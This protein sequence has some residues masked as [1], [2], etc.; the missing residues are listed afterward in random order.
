MTS[1]YCK[2][3]MKK[4]ELVFIPFPAIGHL[5]PTVE[6]AKLLTQRDP[7]LSVTIFIMSFSFEFLDIIMTNNCSHDSVRFVK[8]PPVDACPEAI[9]ALSISQFL[10]ANI[11]LVRNAVH[12]LTRSDSVRLAGFVLDMGFT[13]LIDLADDFGVPSYVFVTPG[14]AFLGFLLHL[15]FLHDHQGLDIDGFKDSDAELEVPSY[16]NSVPGKIFPSF[17]FDKGDSG[18]EW[19]LNHSRRY[20]QVRG[21]I[22]NTFVELESHAIRSFSGT[23]LPPLYAVGPIVNAQ[24][25]FGED[26]AIK[27]WLDDQPPSSVVFLCFGS[28]GAFGVDQIKEIAIALEHSGHRFLWSLRRLPPKGKMGFPR[29]YTNV[30]DVL[31][32]GFL[33]RTASIGKV[34][35]WTPQVAV[36]AHPAVGGFISH[37]GWN[38]ILESIW[39]GVPI[40][41]WP[42]YHEQPLNAFQ[43]VKD[44]ALV[45]EIKIGYHQD[46]GYIVSAQEIENGLKNLMSI[47]SEVRKKS[48]EMQETS[49]KVL[50]DGGSS[51]TTLGRFIEDVMANVS[52]K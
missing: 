40:A 23:T 45:I 28:M 27:R 7:R 5:G 31:P 18:S 20:R 38:S 41:T 19:I 22:V 36:L 50:M 9:T 1:D 4:T 33:Y 42:M 24:T 8:L 25:G 17:L 43:M 11:P 6:I 32:Q 29:E 10:K 37:C 49:R 30:E 51:H 13:H 35:G 12:D 52:C 48:K 15:Q 44:L 14:A 39:Y 47:N 3:E 26:Q 16:V 46:S 2:L 21:I 34:I